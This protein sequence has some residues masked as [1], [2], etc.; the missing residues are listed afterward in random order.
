MGRAVGEAHVVHGRPAGDVRRVWKPEVPA[1]LMPRKRHALLGGLDHVL[2]VKQK[3]RVPNG[4]AANLRH[5]LAEHKLRQARCL[6][7]LLGDMV[8]L[9]AMADVDVIG[10]QPIHLRMHRLD[11]AIARATQN[12][13]V[14]FRDGPFQNEVSLLPKLRALFVRDSGHVI[15]ADSRTTP[16][17][18]FVDRR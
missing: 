18:C 12:G 13:E 15:S 8:A 4:R 3:R 1:V 10:A 16:H 2:V 5:Q 17:S 7:V 11:Q 9:A 6:F 14:R